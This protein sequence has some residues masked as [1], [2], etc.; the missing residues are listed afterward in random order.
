MQHNVSFPSLSNL[1]DRRDT[2]HQ[3]KTNPQK[4][5]HFVVMDHFSSETEFW[6]KVM[7]SKPCEWGRRVLFIPKLVQQFLRA[8]MEVIMVV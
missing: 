3:K 5:D 6:N 4:R 2:S 8:K 7:V 1:D